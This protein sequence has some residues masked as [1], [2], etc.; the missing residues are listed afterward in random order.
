MSRHLERLLR[1][2]ELIRSDQRHTALSLAQQLEVSER[3]IRND[4]AFLRDRYHAPLQF[5][6]QRGLHYTDPDWRLPSIPLS[7]EEFL[8]LTRSIKMFI[9]S[10]G[11]AFTPELESALARL[12]ERLPEG[13]QTDL[14][15]HDPITFR[16][17]AELHYDSQI[18]HA[19]ERAC[20]DHRTVRMIYYTASRDQHTERQLDPYL[21]QISFGSE[22]YVVGYCHRRQEVRTFRV[23]RIQELEIL[24]HRFTL[25]PEFDRDKLDYAF[26]YELGG[27]PQ[28]VSIW[29]AP[30]KA[31]FIRERRW[32]FT[33]QIEEHADRSLTLHLFVAGF[34]DLKR[35]VLSFGPGAKVIAPP[36]LATLVREEIWALYQLHFSD[37]SHPPPDTG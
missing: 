11:A 5:R 28:A 25:D 17:G 33:Q 4:L 19:L 24:D 27:D 14:Q 20:Y 36:E 3:T 13:Y 35:W 29:F 32:H 22:A 37:Q 15:Q 34:Q 26:L 1:I 2:D 10:S 8:A 30:D 9:S 7:G 23:D 21:V 6:R 18:F 31:P 16:K 12:V